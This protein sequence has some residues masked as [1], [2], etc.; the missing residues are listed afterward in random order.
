MQLCVFNI[1]CFLGLLVGASATD[2]RS[3]T[4]KDNYRQLA[5]MNQDTDNGDIDE[6]NVTCRHG[7]GRIVTGFGADLTKFGDF[8]VAYVDKYYSALSCKDIMQEF[9]KD[10]EHRSNFVKNLPEWPSEN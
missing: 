4:L 9:A 6:E 8:I 2:D 10:T 1:A 7:L 3:A 5:Q